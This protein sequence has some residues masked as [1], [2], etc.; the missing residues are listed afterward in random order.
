MRR[1]LDIILSARIQVAEAKL[2]LVIRDRTKWQKAISNL[3][4]T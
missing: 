2:A 1:H 3:E 4:R